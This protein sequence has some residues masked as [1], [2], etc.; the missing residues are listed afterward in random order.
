MGGS[1]VG[2]FRGRGVPAGRKP[3]RRLHEG[4]PDP[5]PVGAWDGLKLRS[6]CTALG[7]L[8]S[9]APPW[10]AEAAKSRT[11]SG[12]RPT[13][14]SASGVGM[15]RLRRTRG[16]GPRAI[17]PFLGAFRPF[18][19]SPPKPPSTR[20]L[21]GFH[22][23]R[24]GRPSWERRP[25]FARGRFAVAGLPMPQPPM[26]RPG[27]GPGRR[28][29]PGENPSSH[30]GRPALAAHTPPEQQRA[31]RPQLSAVPTRRPR[32][33]GGRGRLSRAGPSRG[34]RCRRAG[35]GRTR[36]RAGSPGRPRGRARRRPGGS[37]CRCR[38]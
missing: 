38:R 20:G 26:G 29:L 16:V 27:M 21:L 10:M 32:R 13:G 11:V 12:R 24:A 36:C 22:T 5:T 35:R 23:A 17:A 15:R 14:E 18:P 31:R 6:A 3:R 2:E 7:G 28:P 1:V 25:I 8:R 19:A 9:P 34:S 33:P 4:H 30:E 37:P